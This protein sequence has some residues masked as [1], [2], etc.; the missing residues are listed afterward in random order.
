V[1]A[2]GLDLVVSEVCI[3]RKKKVLASTV[4]VVGRACS[5]RDHTNRVSG[6][7]TTVYWREQG[8][9]CFG[10][11]LDSGNNGEYLREACL[12]AH[13]RPTCVWGRSEAIHEVTRLRAW[14][15]RGTPMKTR[16]KLACFSMSR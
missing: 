3:P 7:A 5:L 6:V 1:L 4:F 8:P 15:F 13:W 16:G 11:K 2:L 9:R 14:P 10:H 12:K